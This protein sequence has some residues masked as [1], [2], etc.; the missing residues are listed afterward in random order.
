[1]RYYYAAAVRISPRG[2]SPSQLNEDLYD[3]SL[4]A[5]AIP[6][7]L[8]R[9]FYLDQLVIHE[10][11]NNVS[12]IFYNFLSS[13]CTLENRIRVVVV[14]IPESSTIRG[15]CITIYVC[16]TLSARGLCGE[17]CLG[18]PNPLFLGHV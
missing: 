10:I 7:K 8:S 12:V 4:S 14:K 2:V 3:V 6:S 5:C 9:E 1:V 17:N 18:P 13:C 11:R 16:H 15:W